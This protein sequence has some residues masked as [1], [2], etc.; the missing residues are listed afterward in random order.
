MKRSWIILALLLMG[1]VIGGVAWRRVEKVPDVSARATPEARA[2]DLETNGSPDP[3]LEKLPDGYVALRDAVN[4]A[5]SLHAKSGDAAL[6]LGSLEQ[7]FE[8]YRFVFKANPVGSENQEIMA[9]LLGNNAK[10][11]VFF[12]RNHPSLNEDGVLLDRWGTPYYFHPLSAQLMDMR[13]AGPDGNLWTDDD[14]S[15]GLEMEDEVKALKLVR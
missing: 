12:P 4:L 1:L 11:L 3:R 10:K 2:A 9:Q 13:T 14:L 8:L 7:V 15:L 6:D 5:N